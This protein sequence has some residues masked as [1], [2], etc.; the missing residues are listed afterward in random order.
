MINYNIFILNDMQKT[1]SKSINTENDKTTTDVEEL[2][3]GGFLVSKSRSYKV[4]DD[5]KYE[6]IKS[7]EKQN[8]LDEKETSKEEKSED[9]ST[10]K[11]DGI[12]K[13]LSSDGKPKINLLP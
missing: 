9:E 11:D 2:D 8:P 4:G 10:E 13:Y 5:W 3:G 6:N 12:F 1:W 7:F